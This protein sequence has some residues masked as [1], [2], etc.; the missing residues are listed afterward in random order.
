MGRIYS[1]PLLPRLRDHLGENAGDCKSWGSRWLQWNNN[2]QTQQVSCTYELTVLMTTCTRPVQTPARQNPNM[3]DTDGHKVSTLA[4][5][6]L[7]AHSCWKRVSFLFFFKK[8]K[9]SLCVSA[10][11]Y[12]NMSLDAHGCQRHRILLELGSLWTTK[13]RCWEMNLG[14]LK[15]R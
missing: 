14:P 11:E 15:D 3:E 10:S 5:E 4:D 1:H 2:C 8:L 13:H 7:A 12:V 6:L 9:Y